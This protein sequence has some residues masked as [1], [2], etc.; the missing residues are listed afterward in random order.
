MKKKLL[1]IGLTLVAIVGI[2]AIAIAATPGGESDPVVTKSYV[3]Q[4]IAGVSANGST[5]VATLIPQGKSLIGGEG[6]EIILR[7]GKATAVAT[8]VNGVTDITG[9]KDL[10]N[11]EA[12]T[13][14]HLLIVPRDDGRGIKASVDSYV[15]VRGK[16]TI[17]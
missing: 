1:I 6:T 16:Y 2:S 17:K 15:L 5:Y 7:S 8:G 12:V 14:E 3:D 9:A 4:K 13:L 10:K 11:G